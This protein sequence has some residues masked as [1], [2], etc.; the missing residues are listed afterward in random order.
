MSTIYGTG[1]IGRDITAA[2]YVINKLT[3]SM[4]TAIV[5][6]YISKRMAELGHGDNY[7]VRLRHFVMQPDDTLEI[8]S[9]DHLYILVERVFGV[10]IQST[11]GF[12]DLASSS[13]NELQ[14]EHQGKIEINNYSQDRVDVRF[15]QA[16]PVPQN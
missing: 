5:M 10:S 13:V 4:D 1:G 3:N 9:S 12:F 14:Y 2:G 15:V 6:D 7:H 8:E 11:F 16:I